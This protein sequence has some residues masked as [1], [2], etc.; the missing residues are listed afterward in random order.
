MVKR[1][2]T[3]SSWVVTATDDDNGDAT[4]MPNDPTDN[5]GPS[6][7]NNTDNTKDTKNTKDTTNTGPTNTKNTGPTDERPTDEMSETWGLAE[8][9]LIA[10][11]LAAVADLGGGNLFEAWLAFDER[12]HTLVV[13]KI[14]ATDHVDRFAVFRPAWLARSRCSPACSHP[15]IVRMFVRPRRADR[16]TTPYL[17]LEYI[18]G[19]TC[20]R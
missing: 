10:P 20:R 7:T 15:G 17:V 6:N 5:T 8:G 9:D 16:R 14:A 12:L 11:G 1:E 19:P 18:D 4:T 2:D 13:V 3:A